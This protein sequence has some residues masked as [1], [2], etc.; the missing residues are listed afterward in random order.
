MSRLCTWEKWYSL[1]Q[2]VCRL[3]LQQNIDLRI[4]CQYQCN[5]LPQNVYQF[6]HDV[7]F[8]CRR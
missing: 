1:N 8:L 2:Q 4:N 3:R 7:G 5:T 6:V